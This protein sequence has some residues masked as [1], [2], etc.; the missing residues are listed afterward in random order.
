MAGRPWPEWALQSGSWRDCAGPCCVIRG[1]W[2]LELGRLARRRR[3]PARRQHG[4]SMARVSALRSHHP[5]C[6]L[7]ARGL[8]G[9]ADVPLSARRTNLH[10]TMVFTRRVSL[11]SM[12]LRGWAV[13]AFRRARAR[14]FA[15]GGRLVVRK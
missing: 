7:H 8:M 14:S 5:V 11:V 13:D 4:L 6:R 3:N 9:G 15:I 1:R 12:A 10:Y 2:L